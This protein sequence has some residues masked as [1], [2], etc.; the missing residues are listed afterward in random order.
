[1]SLSRIRLLPQAEA[2]IKAARRWYDSERPGLGEEF[3]EAVEECFRR[4][5]S[6]PTAFPLVYKTARKALV[7]RFPYCVYFVADGSRSNVV[8]VLHGKRAPAIWQKRL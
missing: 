4:V 8:A 7:N 6:R 1:M 5:A 2:D 3:V